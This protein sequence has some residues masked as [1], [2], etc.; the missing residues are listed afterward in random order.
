MKE[1]TDNVGSDTK[2]KQTVL[3]VKLCIHPPEKVAERRYEFFATSFDPILQ[4]A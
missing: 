1:L 4:R 2:H 3:A